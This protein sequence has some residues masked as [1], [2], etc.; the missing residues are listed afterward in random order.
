MQYGFPQSG[1]V[2]MKFIYSQKEKTCVIEE[3]SVYTP[4][5]GENIMLA[6]FPLQLQDGTINISINFGMDM[7]TRKHTGINEFATNN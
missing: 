1:C 6:N 2:S 3:V 5:S 4:P 7:G